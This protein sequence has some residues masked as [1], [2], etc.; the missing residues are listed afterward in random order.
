MSEQKYGDDIAEVL[1]ENE[2]RALNLAYEVVPESAKN[3]LDIGVSELPFLKSWERNQWVVGLVD[4]AYDAADKLKEQPKE[5]QR[6]DG[7]TWTEASSDREP[8][9]R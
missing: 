5:A 1:N 9:T 2:Q 7:R 3:I 8:R 6:N 4:F